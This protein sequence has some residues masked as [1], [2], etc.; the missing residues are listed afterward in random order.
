MEYFYLSVGYSIRN[1]FYFFDRID[2]TKNQMI[3]DCFTSWSHIRL[4]SS[5]RHNL[6]NFQFSFTR[7]GFCKVI[8][9]ELTEFL[10]DCVINA[11]TATTPASIVGSILRKIF[12]LTIR[13]SDWMYVTKI[14]IHFQEFRWLRLKSS[15]LR[16]CYI[17]EYQS[18]T[19]DSANQPI[20][21]AT[22]T[23]MGPSHYSVRRYGTG[24][25]FRLI[26]SN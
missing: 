8:C 9:I 23:K 2:L 24:K 5:P 16:E 7:Y 10:C 4:Q 6:D 3:V 21:S 14:S 1:G 19:K 26:P 17:Q 15:V 13:M 22:I 12:L 18:N 20:T 11:I 25:A